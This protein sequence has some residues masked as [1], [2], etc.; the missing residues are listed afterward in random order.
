MVS[1]AGSSSITVR[2]ICFTTSAIEKLV[3]TCSSSTI[4]VCKVDMSLN[5]IGSLMSPSTRTRIST[6]PF[7]SLSIKS[8][9][10]RISVPGLKKLRIFTS[11]VTFVT[12]TSPTE[13]ST[14]PVPRTRFG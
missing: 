5:V 9:L 3:D 1:K 6:V 11:T 12:P 7:I 2:C 8:I 4:K 14:K 13:T 10:S